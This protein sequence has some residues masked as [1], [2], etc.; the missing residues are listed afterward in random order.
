MKRL[1]ALAL[2]L[3]CASDNYPHL[4]RASPLA[5]GYA[6]KDVSEL[7]HL[8]ATRAATGV[9]FSVYSAHATRMELAVFED[10]ESNHPTRRFL[11]TRFGDV[12]N[13]FIEGVGVGTDYGYIAWGPNWPYVPT[14]EPGTTDGFVAD[15]DQDGNRFNP[16][17]LL[18]DP[19]SRAFHRD[20]DW[21]KGST[22][23]GPRRADLTY[24]ASAKSVV[25]QSAY[26]WSTN[27]S[28][29]RDL[30]KSG[31]TAPHRWQ[32]LIIYEVHP[33]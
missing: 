20:H 27:E 22:A 13:V 11:M 23:S 24:A 14:W 16:N 33:K 4:Y 3:S 31:A 32:D 26:R 2:C 19:Y 7:R 6:S 28:S 29:W 10:P 1:A 21:S 30:R 9:N 15:I 8:G 17:K 12:W 5:P 25:V 18:F